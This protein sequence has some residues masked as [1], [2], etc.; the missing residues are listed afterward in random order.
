M[1]MPE[2]SSTAD[3]AYPRPLDR[4][5]LGLE[6]DPDDPRTWSFVVTPELSRT[7][8][9]FYGG[10]ALAAALTASEIVTGRAAL[11]STTQ[12]V[13]TADRGERIRLA[14][15][16]V[17]SGRSVDQVHVRGLVGERL[18]FNAVGAT[19]T[20]RTGAVAGSGQVMPAVPRPEDCDDWHGI[21]R[22]QIGG[23]GASPSVGAPTVG[24]HLVSEYRAAPLLD[25][26]TDRPGHLA[27]W[28][29]LTSDLVSAPTVMSPAAIGFVA[30]MVPIAVCRACGVEGAGTSLDNSLRMGHPVETEWVLLELDAHVAVGGFG[31][32]HVHVWS[33][34]GVMLATGTQSARLFSFSDFMEQ[35]A[36]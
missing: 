12:L 17:A 8:G 35:L 26:F 20:P 36:R 11:W 33:P 31:H 3:A 25:P 32:G 19:A 29:R 15:D 24:H 18:V 10:A 5:L 6:P 13:A 14:V 1:A 34:D 22:S 27:L 16:V 21:L 30:D 23:D 7:D 9:R 4:A 2:R 28:A